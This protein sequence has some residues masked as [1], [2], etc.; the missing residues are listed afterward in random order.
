LAINDANPAV[1][2]SLKVMK[3]N[4]TRDDFTRARGE[5]VVEFFTTLIIDYKQDDHNAVK[6]WGRSCKLSPLV[7][8]CG[9]CFQIQS[10]YM[11]QRADAVSTCAYIKGMAHDPT[12]KRWPFHS[13]LE[14]P[15][16]ICWDVPWFEQSS[17]KGKPHFVYETQID[18]RTKYRAEYPARIA[19]LA[20]IQ[21]WDIVNWHIY[22]HSADSSKEN[23]FDGQIQ[24]W[25]DYLGYGSDEVQ[26][27]AMKACAEIFKNGLLKP[28]PKPT[29]FTFGRR[30]LYDP[31]S[32]DYGRSY[33]D[34]GKKVIPTCF[35]YG[36][37]FAIDPMREDDVVEGPTQTQG[38][39]EPCP[40]RP[41]EQIEYDWSRGG[42]IFDAPGTISFSGFFGQ[43]GGQVK[44][45]NG[46]TIRNVTVKNPD[47]IAYPV[48]PEEGYVAITL[49]SAD[50]KPLTETKKAYLS[51]VSTSF[52]TGFKL[53]L[54]KNCPGMHQEG[55]KKGPP[56]EFWGAYP[57]TGK[58]PVLVA[59]VGAT[60]ECKAIDG[61]KYVLRDWHMRPIGE[62]KVEG[63]T[64]TISSQQP[65]FI[66]ELSR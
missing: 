26:C 17:V 52:N 13:G 39:Y 21:D 2:E 5:D 28:A 35:R 45:S 32:M 27:S 56:Q 53:D 30:S 29:T 31:A 61:M 22:G 4:F 49:A 46:N 23:P 59:R 60:I 47:G 44:L 8:D 33:G 40:V 24:V 64:I 14:A 18:C 15:P 66:V 1:I 6:T 50:G 11:H 25:H 38:V 51:A 65:V 3:S 43:C 62:G 42:L 20:A 16:R 57:V 19:A 12:Y 54:T 58:A 55:P 48:T 36:L 41:N 63:G 34:L 9:N 10:T 7:W 37:R